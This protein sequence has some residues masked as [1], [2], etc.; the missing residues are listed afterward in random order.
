LGLTLSIGLNSTDPETG[1]RLPGAPPEVSG[2]LLSV[3]DQ[4][5]A[6]TD[7][8]VVLVLD[9]QVRHRE[10]VD[11]D[12]RDPGDPMSGTVLAN[13]LVPHPQLVRVH[14]SAAQ[15]LAFITGL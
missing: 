11:F 10:H 7:D 12:L 6:R 5:R 13:H 2:R 8:V 1:S 3:V 15:R 4:N 9:C 14:P